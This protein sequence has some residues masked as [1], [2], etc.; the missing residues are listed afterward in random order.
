MSKENY[1]DGSS[2]C[3]VIGAWILEVNDKFFRYIQ[4]KIY[5]HQMYS[6]IE[7]GYYYSS[8]NTLN[9]HLFINCPFYI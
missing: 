1:N 9:Q 3:L 2:G 6:F 5:N 4:R 8:H 7:N